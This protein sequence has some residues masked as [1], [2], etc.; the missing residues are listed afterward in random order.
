ML[1][2]V[3]DYADLVEKA[4]E[5]VWKLFPQAVSCFNHF[6]AYNWLVASLFCSESSSVTWKHCCQLL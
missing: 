6:I 3:N 5:E 4:L 1:Y 2:C